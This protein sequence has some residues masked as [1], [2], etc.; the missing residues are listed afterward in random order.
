MK[1]PSKVICNEYYA[2]MI[3]DRQKMTKKYSEDADFFRT[4]LYKLIL[5]SHQISC[6]WVFSLGY[7]KAM[8]RF[9]TFKN[10][11]QTNGD[12]RF[13]FCPIVL[14]Y[15]ILYLLIMNKMPIYFVLPL[16]VSFSRN[17]QLK[18]SNFEKNV[19]FPDGRNRAGTDGHY[20]FKNL[21]P[22]TYDP[23]QLFVSQTLS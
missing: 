12:G 21:N 22:Y 3:I 16:G 5:T 23:C 14:K 17:Q 1:K 9:R 20:F 13:I 15:S 11:V 19:T 4:H 2:H 6:L 8:S 18:T 7:C 10:A